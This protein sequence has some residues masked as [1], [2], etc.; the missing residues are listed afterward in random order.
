MNKNGII[1]LRISYWVGAVVDLVAGLIMTFPGFYAVFNRIPGFKATPAFLNVAWMGAPLMFGWTVLLIWA[2]RKPVE[3]KE[4]LLITLIPIIGNVINQVASVIT[5]F[6]SLSVA[7][8]QWALQTLLID[9][10]SYSYWVAVKIS[11][12]NS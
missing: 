3:R 11:K 6:T 5:G 2:D 12:T 8:P 7:V 4:I 1:L 10:F 9:L